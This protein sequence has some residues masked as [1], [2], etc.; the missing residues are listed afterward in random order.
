M[1]NYPIHKVSLPLNILIIYQQ[2]AVGDH[3]SWTTAIDKEWSP[4]TGLAF[5]PPQLLLLCQRHRLQR[6][7]RMP[8]LYIVLLLSLSTCL[9]HSCLPWLLL[10]SSGACVR[11][12]VFV[13]FA[14][15]V[16]A[17][18]AFMSV[19]HHLAAASCPSSGK[20]RYVRILFIDYSFAFNNVV[21]YRKGMSLATEQKEQTV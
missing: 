15:L 19:Y 10:P 2:P 9:V 1:S 7:N 11:A 5:A 17:H 16:H 13:S 3:L 6:N 20:G 18:H 14:V 21:S 4:K 12:C 8:T